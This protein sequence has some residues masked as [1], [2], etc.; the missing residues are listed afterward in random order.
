MGVTKKPGGKERKTPSESSSSK[1][2]QSRNELERKLE[3][4]LREYEWA[5]EELRVAV[6]KISP[7]LE[8]NPSKQALGLIEYSI[9]ENKLLPP[10]KSASIDLLVYELSDIEKRRH[11]NQRFAN[12]TN[13]VYSE[14]DKWKADS[15]DFL[16]DVI[17]S[18]ADLASLHPVPRQV[19]DLVSEVNTKLVENPHINRYF[20]YIRKVAKDFSEFRREPHPWVYKF[21]KAFLEKD[22]LCTYSDKYKYFT[23]IP[24]SAPKELLFIISRG[25]TRIGDNA[26]ESTEALALLKVVEETSKIYERYTEIEIEEFFGDFRFSEEEDPMEVIRRMDDDLII[27]KASE[28]ERECFLIKNKNK[29][30]TGLRTRKKR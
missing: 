20:N 28:R 30:E 18:A 1:S 19:I 15:K 10:S 16:G 23:H 21:I 3:K 9:K 12:H 22:P 14:M 13:W 27:K 11:Q 8:L 5:G 26:S 17:E 29:K 25:L 6:N 24:R 2:I 4:L 7:L